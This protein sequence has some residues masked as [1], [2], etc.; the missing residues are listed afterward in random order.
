VAHRI[1]RPRLLRHRQL[2][3]GFCAKMGAKLSVMLARK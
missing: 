2:S 1:A 3:A